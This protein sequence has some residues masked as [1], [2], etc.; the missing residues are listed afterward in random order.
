MDQFAK[1]ISEN[2]DVQLFQ[3]TIFT[4]KVVFPEKIPNNIQIV[5][6]RFMNKIKDLCTKKAH[7]QICPVWQA[8]NDEDK[9]LLLTS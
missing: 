6:S 5:N 9:N 4:Q 1:F 7:E 8:Y 2:A 3:Y